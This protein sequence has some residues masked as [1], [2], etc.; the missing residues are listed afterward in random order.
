LPIHDQKEHLKL[1]HK[2]SQI[3]Q[4]SQLDKMVLL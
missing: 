4:R 2:K 1:L 3:W